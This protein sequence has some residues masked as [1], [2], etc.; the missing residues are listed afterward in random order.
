MRSA[1]HA[2]IHLKA[3]AHNV[4]QIRLRA[5]S[6]KLMA[7]V[8]ANAYGHGLVRVAQALAGL[9]DGFAVARVEEGV[10][11]RKSGL[12][13]RIVV[14]E[15]FVSEAELQYLLDYDLEAS[16]H[17]FH[18]LTILTNTAPAPKALGVWLKIDTGMNRLGFKPSEVPGV[19]QHLIDLKNVKKPLHFMS[20]FANAD[21]TQ[22]P[23]TQT[24][25]ARFDELTFAYNG[26]KSIANSAGILG[27]PNTQKD[28][29][30]AGLL[31]YGI[32][33]FFNA[34]GA[35]LNL[36]PLMS[37]HSRI[38]A[39][40]EVAAGETVGYSSTWTSPTKTKLGV[41]AIGYGDGYPRQA[42]NGTPVLIN[43]TRVPIVGR[44]SMDMITVDL[45][46]QSSVKIGDKATLWGD[47][48]PVEEI[49]TWANTI[50]YT[51][52]CGIT[53]RVAMF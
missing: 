35:E 7:V 4:K 31:L 24:Q 17:A 51:L 33:P 38:I 29:I 1:T 28:W 27:W 10:K 43:D 39:I 18:Q 23:K 36:K 16:L 9:V 45:G 20:H 53:Q 48:L 46:L 25:L 32:S 15:G 21:D 2:I 26:E 47:G 6:S 11:L 8:K 12:S 30:R 14:L 13:E 19:Y 40:R 34:T 44:V 49:A 5:P 37:L 50:P 52:V 42:K 41:I 3:L 22:D